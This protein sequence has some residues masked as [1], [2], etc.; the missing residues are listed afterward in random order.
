MKKFQ[1]V[2]IRK[3]AVM[4]EFDSPCGTSRMSVRVDQLVDGTPKELAEQIR[5]L[6]VAEVATM[7]TEVNLSKLERFIARRAYNSKKL[8]FPIDTPIVDMPSD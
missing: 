7:K 5:L 3:N 2:A 8:E 4:V 6:V 1:I